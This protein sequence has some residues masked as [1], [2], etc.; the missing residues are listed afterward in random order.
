ML[1]LTI[2][3]FLTFCQEQTSTVSKSK[4]EK[5]NTHSALKIIDSQKPLSTIEKAE[6]LKQFPS[7]ES[8]NVRLNKIVIGHI[9]LSNEIHTLKQQDQDY[10]KLELRSIIDA[11]E[12]EITIHGKASNN[13]TKE[14]I[15]LSK[16]R[17]EL[18]NMQAAK[19][20]L[21]FKLN[22]E[23]ELLEQQLTFLAQK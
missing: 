4:N 22:Y 5:T 1:L 16:E 21:L 19:S 23:K 2:S 13:L 7:T 17:Q 12:S 9:Q 11:I 15:R 14:R 10:Y 3:P 8:I 20:E 6:Y 18:I